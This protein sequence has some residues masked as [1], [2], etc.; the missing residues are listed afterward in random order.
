MSDPRLL[1]LVTGVGFGADQQ[2]VEPADAISDDRGTID[3]VRGAVRQLVEA[4][5]YRPRL[6]IRSLNRNVNR[7]GKNLAF[8]R[9]RQDC[10]GFSINGERDLLECF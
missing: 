6:Q 9:K 1:H 3:A 4:L 8:A 2:L 10:L 5:L 7:S